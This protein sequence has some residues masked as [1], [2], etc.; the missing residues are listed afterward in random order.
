MSKHHAKSH[1]WKNGILETLIHY[2]DSEDEATEFANNSDAHSV[3]VYNPDG[4]L[5]L[6]KNSTITDSYASGNTY[7]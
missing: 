2:F 4:E 1:H 7:A 6:T 5:L 3:K